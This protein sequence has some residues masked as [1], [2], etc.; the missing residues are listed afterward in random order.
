MKKRF[1]TFLIL[2]LF[3]PV[4]SWGQTPAAIPEAMTK[5]QA[6]LYLQMYQYL[7][8]QAYLTEEN[9][10]DA[11]YLWASLGLYGPPTLR[12]EEDESE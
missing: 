9:L 4:L 6:R 2:F 12:S 7:L 3:L 10:E 1:K 8:D 11:Y 5:D